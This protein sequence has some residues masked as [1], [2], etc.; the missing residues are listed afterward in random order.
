[1]SEAGSVSY[2]DLDGLMARMRGNAKIIKVLLT[3]FLG[4]AQVDQ[5]AQE[6]ESGDKVAASHTAH[7]IKGVAGNLSL[8]SLYEASL[9]LESLLKADGNVEEFFSG[10]KEIYAKTRQSVEDTLKTL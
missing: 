7:A 3:T 2:L 5:L 6:I 1:M 4:E 9:K 10:Y 8:T